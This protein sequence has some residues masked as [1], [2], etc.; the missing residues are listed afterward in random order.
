MENGGGQDDEVSGEVWEIVETDTRKIR[1]GETERRGG[2]RGSR[3]KERRKGEK[4]EAEKRE[5]NGGEEGS[6]GM[7]NMG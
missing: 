5:N 7:G 6:R 3:E 4:E 1:I 2:K